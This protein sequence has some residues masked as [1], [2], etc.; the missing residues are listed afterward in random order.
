[1]DPQLAAQPSK[2]E[3]FGL[4]HLNQ[5]PR[6]GTQG[7][8]FSPRDEELTRQV[9][10][11]SAWGIFWSGLVGLIFVFP[12]I[13][14]DIRFAN[15][16]PWI[17]YGW[18][19]GVMTVGT[20]IEF[21]CIFYI[22]LKA[23]HEVSELMRLENVMHPSLE[24]G[25]FGVKN[26]LARTALE[27]DDPK[28]RI[29]GIDPFKQISKRNLFVI[30]LLYKGKIIVTNLA[31]KAI[32]R[33]FV[34]TALFGIPILYVAIPVEMF[35]NGLV[36]FKVIHEARLRLF[37]YALAN[38]I[39]DSIEKEGYLDILSPS[40]KSGCLRAIGNAVVMTQ[41][42]HP[43]M[44]V[45]LLR[46][47][48]LLGIDVEDRYDD[49]LPFIET[50]NE[51]GDKERNFLLDLLTVAAAFDGKLSKSEK[52]HLNEAYQQD[53]GIYLKRLKDLTAYL[54]CGKINSALTLCRLDFIKG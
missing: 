22:S 29:L 38:R 31:L 36:I 12:M 3:R 33:L 20:I 52:E 34:G 16:A 45:L 43:N 8:A 28:L 11:I 37:G 6:T 26:I 15:D 21:Y 35:W 39:A 4:Y 48:T 2:F 9:N 50:L 5:F 30:G 44:V 54:K 1:M 46:F 49:W 24:E 41:N 47:Q 10:R 19:I 40:A 13:Y 27:I 42:Y 25:I 14:V 18:V 32:L 23:V 7:D 53:A 17:H 51:V